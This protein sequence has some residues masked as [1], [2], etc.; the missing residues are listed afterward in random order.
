[1]EGQQENFTGVI[2][3]LALARHTKPGLAPQLFVNHHHVLHLSPA[4]SSVTPIN[5]R[6]DV[7]RISFEHG[8]HAPIREV[9]DESTQAEVSSSGSALRS[10][11]HALH[12]ARDQD[13]DPLRTHAEPA[14]RGTSRKQSQLWHWGQK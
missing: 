12:L 3:T 11:E 13:T 1:M 6:I 9:A 7:G 2:S 4:R 8:F 10:K 14:L 5:E